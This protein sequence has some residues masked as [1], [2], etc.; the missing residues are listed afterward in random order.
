MR[1]V[2]ATIV[3][4]SAAGGGATCSPVLIRLDCRAGSA[5]INDNITHKP[6]AMPAITIDV[7][8]RGSVLCFPTFSRLKS[9]IARA[10]A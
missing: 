4:L 2:A 1:G 7:A 8:A 10:N 6:T 3:T 9:G 5:N